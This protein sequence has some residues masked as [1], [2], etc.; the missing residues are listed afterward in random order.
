MEKEKG[1]QPVFRSGL[2]PEHVTKPVPILVPIPVPILVPILVMVQRNYNP[3]ATFPL[4][5]ISTV[6]PQ[7]W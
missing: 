5:Y 3:V 4:S 6:L 1:D 7:Q 2:V